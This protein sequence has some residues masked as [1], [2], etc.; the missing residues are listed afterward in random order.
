MNSKPKIP[1]WFQDGPEDVEYRTYKLRACVLNLKKKLASDN[2]LECLIEIDDTLDYLYRYD[3]VKMTQDQNPIGQ[4]V[5]GFEIPGLEFYYS[6]AE[7]IETNDI[8]DLILDEAIDS[9]EEL[10]AV[11]RERWRYIE[12]GLTCGYVPSKPYFISDGFVFIKTP[13][14]MLHIYHFTKPNKYFTD[15]WKKFKMT[16]MCT[17]KWT[18]ET[19]FNRLEE[20]ISKKSD[21]IM[22]RME[23]KTHTILEN[24][25]I[26][27]INQKIFL[28]L[29]KDYSF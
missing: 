11:C 6:T 10:H 12:E 19:Y 22:I 3:A 9:Y 23:C 20:V 18:K 1:T 7:E 28:M 29:S 15:D 14:D 24:D 13:D 25:A 16:H 21:K 8:L 27:V 17:E 26:G 5:G 2:L 4:I